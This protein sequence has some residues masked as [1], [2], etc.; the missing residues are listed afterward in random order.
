M[1]ET[2][3]REQWLIMSYLELLEI[4]EKED[5]LKKYTIQ[6]QQLE[7]LVK[8]TLDKMTLDKIAL[9]EIPSFSNSNP[10]QFDSSS[11]AKRINDKIGRLEIEMAKQCEKKEQI[12][13]GLADLGVSFDLNNDFNDI[14][15]PN[16]T[17]EELSSI[18]CKLETM[19]G[20]SME[21]IMIDDKFDAEERQQQLDKELKQLKE[22]LHL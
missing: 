17:H 2:N 6:W 9:D 22:D 4:R 19:L 13:A 10:D 18:R 15:S 7:Q 21:E 16:N 12:Q 14:P 1:Y 8:M 5:L 11:I 3:N 20:K